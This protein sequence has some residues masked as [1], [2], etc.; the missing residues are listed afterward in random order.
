MTFKLLATLYA[1][2]KA[3]E[4]LIA[5]FEVFLGERAALWLTNFFSA[6]KKNALHFIDD[7]S[8]NWIHRWFVWRTTPEGV[9]YWCEV[10][11]EWKDYLKAKYGNK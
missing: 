7:S 2:D 3:T 8:V 10:D 1:K 6:G 9:E 5:E 4:D 11:D